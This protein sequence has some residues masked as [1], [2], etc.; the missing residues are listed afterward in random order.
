MR[1]ELDSLAAPAAP[2]GKQ[3]R[4]DAAPA[5]TVLL[6]SL[7]AAAKYLAWSS[8]RL[9]VLGNHQRLIVARETFE[10]VELPIQEDVS[11]QVKIIS[12]IS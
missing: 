9:C 2:G 10:V 6:D 3:F 8:P 1:I 5:L 7:A 12:F 4:S 11:M